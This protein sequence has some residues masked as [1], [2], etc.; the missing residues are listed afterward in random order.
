MSGLAQS[1]QR[2]VLLRKPTKPATRERPCRTREQ[3]IKGLQHR[4]LRQTQ[5]PKPKIPIYLRKDFPGFEK[6]KKNR[7]GRRKRKRRG[8]KAKN[9]L[10]LGNSA[11]I[12]HLL[13]TTAENREV[14]RCYEVSCEDEFKEIET[15][16]EVVDLKEE[17]A[18]S[19]ERSIQLE[20]MIREPVVTRVL[21][22]NVGV[23]TLST[24]TS[25]R[26]PAER[27]NNKICELKSSD[28]LIEFITHAEQIQFERHVK[29]KLEV[30]DNW[31]TS[32]MKE[33]ATPHAQRKPITAALKRNLQ[34]VLR[35]REQIQKAEEDRTQLLAQRVL[36]VSINV[37]AERQKRNLQALATFRGCV[38]V[39]AKV[40]YLVSRL[41]VKKQELVKEQAALVLQ[42]RGK[43][44]LLHKLMQREKE[45]R[46][47]VN[48][49]LRRWVATFRK[50]QVV[51]AANIIK[52]V[53][54]TNRRNFHKLIHWYI[55]RVK[56]CQQLARSFL[57]CTKARLLGVGRIWTR[58]EVR[59]AL[60]LR[61]AKLAALKEEAALLAAKVKLTGI[62]SNTKLTREVAV[63]AMVQDDAQEGQ[64]QTS[65]SFPGGISQGC[66]AGS[67]RR[68]DLVDVDSVMDHFLSNVIK[69]KVVKEREGPVNIQPL[70]R[71]RDRLAALRSMLSEARGKSNIAHFLR[72]SSQIAL[73]TS[74]DILGNSIIYIHYISQPF[75]QINCYA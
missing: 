47:V 41:A 15:E 1:G 20:E 48:R 32:N 2:D 58:L 67:N 11:S 72:L 6:G 8:G 4:I 44:F 26:I 12:T 7:K 74:L 66:S 61:D 39:G 75:P 68:S 27:V 35:R 34:A 53:L 56:R 70:V 31:V 33:L 52:T 51:K 59:Y 37:D 73:A 9:S 50:A 36:P 13:D 71:R 57:E 49:F 24:V 45:S 55:C 14:L 38:A 42:E 28:D 46:N 64:E 22:S 54:R 63:P 17:F 21:R 18:K 29:H 40:R 10:G 16:P 62:S 25:A 43:I 23:A 5:P 3:R 69:D 65:I 19:L 60:R 30:G